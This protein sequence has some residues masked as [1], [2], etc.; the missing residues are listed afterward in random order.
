MNFNVQNIKLVKG[1]NQSKDVL[2]P[3]RFLYFTST[4]S[5]KSFH[6]KNVFTREFPKSG[7]T[8]IYCYGVNGYCIQIYV[9]YINKSLRSLFEILQISGKESAKKKMW[10]ALANAGAAGGVKKPR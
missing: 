6:Y 3:R 5:K 7:Q 9:I 4:S 1:M 8:S 10:I 2:P